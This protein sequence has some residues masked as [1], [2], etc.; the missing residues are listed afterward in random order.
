MIK[1][2]MPKLGRGEA[3]FEL[4]YVTYTIEALWPKGEGEYPVPPSHLPKEGKRYTPYELCDLTI[5][6]WMRLGYKLGD[7]KRIKL[8]REFERYMFMKIH[9]DN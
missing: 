4:E 2:Y 8:R 1:Y 3:K 5:G 7:K 9:N 6:S